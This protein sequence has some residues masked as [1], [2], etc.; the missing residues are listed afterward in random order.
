MMRP[1][2]SAIGRGARKVRAK[3]RRD[4]KMNQN[5][6][7]SN[8][9]DTGSIQPSL[10]ATCNMA[11]RLLFVFLLLRFRLSLGWTASACLPGRRIH[12]VPGDNDQLRSAR[13]TDNEWEP[14]NVDQTPWANANEE[15]EDMSDEE[16]QAML[17][18]WDERVAKF[19]T[20][21]LVGRVGNDPDPRYFDDGNVV[22]NLSLACKRKYHYAERVSRKLKSGEEETDWYGLEIW[23]QLAEIVY[24]YVDKGARIG[25]IGSLEVDEW[26]DKE[27]GE[28]QSKAK[29]IVR[30]LEILETKA[31]ADLRRSSQRGPSFYKVDDDDD[32]YD[33]S[34]GSAGGFFD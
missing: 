8:D 12:R 2:V 31:E 30:E 21:H 16:L 10:Q 28:M 18:N 17:G 4:R 15:V 11:S 27:T 6:N 22:V 24:K 3:T 9:N 7:I 29:V 19:N 5:H 34:Q 23:G 13:S 32:K 26:K 33:P 14:P 20:L 1:S 25:V